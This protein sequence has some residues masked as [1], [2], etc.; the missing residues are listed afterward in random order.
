M[1]HKTVMVHKIGVRHL[2]LLRA[3]NND[4]S[5]CNF[6]MYSAAGHTDLMNQGLLPG[7]SWMWIFATQ[8]TIQGT[9]QDN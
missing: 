1:E 3:S 6:L 9:P 5:I 2:K 8:E 4:T 7:D